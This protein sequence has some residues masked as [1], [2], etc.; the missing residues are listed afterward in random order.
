MV[1][2]L[3]VV[4]SGVAFKRSGCSCY[5]FSVNDVIPLKDIN[6]GNTQFAWAVEY[7]A[8]HSGHGTHDVQGRTRAG[9]MHQLTG[10]TLSDAAL[11]AD[12]TR[13]PE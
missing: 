7:R 1:W 6:R 9:R 3:N 4:V 8:G 11:R 10:T 13:I 5:Y 12:G 2:F